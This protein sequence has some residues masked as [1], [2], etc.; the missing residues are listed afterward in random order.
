MATGMLLVSCRK[1]IAVPPPINTITTAEM[2]ES[3]KQANTAMAAVY[4]GMIN[5]ALSFTSGYATLLGGLSADELFYYGALD[6]DMKSFGPNQLLYNNSYSSQV[7]TNLYKVIYTANGVIEGIEG[8]K[9]EALTDSIRN[10]LTGEAKFVRAFCY[11]YLTNFFGDVPL[12]LTVEFN[13]TRYMPKTPASEVYRQVIQ[14]LKEAQSLLGTDYP[15]PAS[16]KER[17]V[18]NKWVVTAMLART[19]LYTGDYANAAAQATAVINNNSVFKLESDLNRVFL[20]DSKEAIWQLKQGTADPNYKN[21]T[22][23]ANTILPSPLATG[24]S[25]HYLTP[26]LMNAFEAGDLRRTA[27]VGSTTN[28]GAGQ[29]WYAYKYK[30]GRHN[31]VTGAASSEY[32]M[33]LRLAEMYL[34]RAEATINNTPGAVEA[35]VADLN[36]IRRRANLIELPKTLTAQQVTTAIAQEKRVELFAEWGHRWLDLKRTKQAHAVLSA[37]PEKQPW[38]GDYQ[39]LYPIPPYEI[40]VN[41]RI[42]QNLDY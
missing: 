28:N 11:F 15:T 4:S 25:Y 33:V 21:G 22:A 10:K 36:E 19:Y 5:G 29:T 24:I 3:D 42:V 23:E 1:M 26:A 30:L 18:P 27:W 14:D 9:S 38:T 6:L 41:P 20:I 40:Q 32:Y 7:W 35:A 8:S 31:T 37:M 13:Q 12:V 39:L 2:F 16:T 34:I 17:I